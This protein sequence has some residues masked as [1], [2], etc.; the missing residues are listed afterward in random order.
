M[1]NMNSPYGQNNMG[2]P[3][4]RPPMQTQGNQNAVYAPPPTPNPAPMIQR[5]LYPPINGRTI[6]HE[7]EI[8]PRDVPMDG[9]VT[10]FPKADFSEIIG[11]YWDGTGTL[12]TMR[13]VLDAP[14][15]QN[16]SGPSV[17]LDMVMAKLNDIEGRLCQTQRP[18]A[19]KRPYKPKQTQNNEEET[20]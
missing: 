5:P 12:Q 20:K 16:G 10:Y 1:G 15:N 9:S 17:S 18:P 13:F 8:T 11:K 19:H 6:T 4:N 2:Y 3:D 14:S 7:D